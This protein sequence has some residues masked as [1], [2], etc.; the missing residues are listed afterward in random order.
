[1]EILNKIKDIIIKKKIINHNK[2]IFKDFDIKIDNES[3]ILVEFNN[4]ISN[5]IGFSYLA[6][7]LKKKYKS[8]IVGYFGN[9]LLVN[10]LKQDFISKIKIFIGKNIG[11]N[12]FSIYKSFGTKDFYFPESN[13]DFSKKKTKI[14]KN[15]ISKVTNLYKLEK[16][17]INNVLVGD[18]LYDTYIKNIVF[19]KKPL[20][21]TV[22]LKDKDFLLFVEDFIYLFL[23]WENYFKQNKIKALIGTHFSYTLAIPLR[24][25]VKNNIET[26]VCGPEVLSRY[27][28]NFYRQNNESFFFKDL[29]K[30]LSKSNKKKI[31]IKSKDRINKRINGRYSTDYSFVT[32]SPFGKIRKKNYLNKNSKL[33]VLI[34]THL[35]GD[36]PHALGN[37]LFPDHY[38]WLKFLTQIAKKTNY[39]WYLKTHPNFG[40]EWTP[41]VK[42]ERYVSENIIKNI[43]NMFLLPS[44]VTHNQLIKEGISAVFTVHGTVGMDYALFNIPVI[45]AS[46]SNPHINYSFNFHPKNI[47]ELKNIILNLGNK[48]KNFKIKKREIFECYAMK[49]VFFSRNWLLQDIDKTL[50]EIGIYHNLWKT[51]FYS[52]W[53]DNYSKEL[54]QKIKKDVFTYTKSKN[55]FLLN[56]NNLG[57]F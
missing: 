32:K 4:F 54:D 6:N 56:N 47:Q 27:K 11:I 48:I 20:I 38:H 34:A 57:K 28:K 22:N 30:N 51:S 39:E 42:H 29:Y 19:L 49:N 46:L 31:I 33:K 12:F 16:F 9:S 7:S 53:V 5:H 40:S 43:K 55:N 14:Y 45:N 36:A 13:I 35:F 15:F 26:F 2:R 18:L 17:K 3:K 37:H 10:P 50:K 23:V 52:H 41:Y 21:P 25:A 1:M 24:L 44:E 8:N